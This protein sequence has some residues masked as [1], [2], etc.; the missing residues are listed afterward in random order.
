MNTNVRQGQEVVILH[1]RGMEKNRP[2]SLLTARDH[3][4]PP[5]PT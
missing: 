5:L 4:G 2:V 3:V 1:G